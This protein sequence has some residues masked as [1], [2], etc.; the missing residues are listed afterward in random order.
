MNS[1]QEKIKNDFQNKKIVV[2]GDLV[3]D[4]FLHG[5][6]D[7]VSRE[8]PVF[9]IRHSETETLAGGAANAAANVASLSGNAVLVGMVGSDE[10]GRRL[11]D[12]LK[13]SGVDCRFV[14]EEESLKT[15]TKIRVLAGQNFAQRKQVVR[16]DYENDTQ[17]G[18]NLNSKLNEH[19]VNACENADA[20]IISDYN[21]GVANEEIGRLCAQISRELEVPLLIDSRSRLKDFSGAATATPNQQEIEQILGKGFSEADC[22]SLRTALGLDAL[23][24][25]L[26][27]EGML[28]L[29]KN[30]SPRKI[31]VIGSKAP[32]DVTGAGDT[33]I[34]TYALGLASGLSFFE[35]ANL[36]NH[37]G[38]NV[39]MKKGTASISLEE[40]CQSL[41]KNP[42]SDYKTHSQ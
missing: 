37:A 12:V 27:S 39:V 42:S 29:E 18:E 30:S 6:I 40:L 3:A 9:I 35:S 31:D 28:L 14:V 26:G 23:L 4:Q 33:V 8:A 15:T 41:E 25:T 7:R 32:V 21:Y 22:E 34:A 19:I 24:V 36:A 17:L 10:N 2:V 38:G 20:I 5:T 1:I 13:S 11:I 16:I